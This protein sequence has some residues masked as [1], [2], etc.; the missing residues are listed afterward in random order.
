[1]WSKRNISSL[2]V[3]VQTCIITL[4]I[5]LAQ[6]TGSSSTSRPAIPLLVIYP[7]DAPT[8]HKDTCSTMFIAALFVIIRNWKQPRCPSTEEWIQG[9]WFI[10]TIE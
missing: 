4:G 1:M 9:I 3:G 5:N 10:Y 2:L 7:K 8:S 6:K